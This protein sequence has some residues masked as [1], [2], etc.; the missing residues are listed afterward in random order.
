MWPFSK[1]R[2]VTTARLPSNPLIGPWR[3]EHGIGQSQDLGDHAMEFSP[4]GELVYSVLESGSVSGRI[5]LT[6][7][8][9]GEKLITDQ[10]SAPREESAPFRVEGPRL[11]IGSPESCAVMVRESEDS[12]TDPYAPLLSV[13]SAAVNHGLAS[14]HPGGPFVPFLMIT[15]EKERRLVRFR[16]RFA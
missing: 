3:F 5:L 1:N 12:R 14:A 4:T 13:G 6:Y 7:R 11:Y 16:C 15:F 10:P 2:K 8:I 9:A